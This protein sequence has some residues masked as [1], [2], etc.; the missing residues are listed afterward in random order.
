MP[1]LVLPMFPPGTTAISDLVSVVRDDDRWE[2]PSTT[3]SGI[4]SN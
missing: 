3:C 2:K 1:Q 4:G